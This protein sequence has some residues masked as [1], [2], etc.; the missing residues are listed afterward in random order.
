MKKLI[1]FLMIVCLLFLLK[2]SSAQNAYIQRFID[3]RAK[4][5]NPNTGYFSPVGAPYHSIET[6]MAE[7]PD[8]GHESTSEA[9]SF[10][11][12]LEAMNGRVTGDWSSLNNALTTLAKQIIPADSLQPTNNAYVNGGAKPTFAA[13][14]PLP[15]MYPSTLDASVPVGIELGLFHFYIKYI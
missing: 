9:Y 5:I 6:L 3:L 15:S 1:N 12:W 11:I 10:W 2:N 7:A 8:Q 4:I 14:Y 13:E